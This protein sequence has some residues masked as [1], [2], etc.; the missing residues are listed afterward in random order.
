MISLLF[1]FLDKI[2]QLTGQHSCFIAGSLW[3][4][5]TLQGIAILTEFCY[6][7]SY[8]A[9]ART[10]LQ[11]KPQLLPSTSSPIHYSLIELVESI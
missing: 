3:E 5:I 9:N 4:Q 10:V 8:Q 11:I 6:P 1:T 7:Q 2:L